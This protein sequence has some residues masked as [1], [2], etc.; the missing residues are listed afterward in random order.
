MP[1][2]T[3]VELV[4]VGDLSRDPL[5]VRYQKALAITRLDR[6]IREASAPVLWQEEL[7]KVREQLEELDTRLIDLDKWAVDRTMGLDERL[8]RVEGRVNNLYDFS[9]FRRAFACGNCGTKAT[10]TFRVKCKCGMETWF[11]WSVA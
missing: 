1:K 4:P 6:D 5:V 9:A 8:E 7:A 11:G 10:I 2:A 3:R